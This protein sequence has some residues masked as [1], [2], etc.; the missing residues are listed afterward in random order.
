MNR[1]A[2]ELQLEGVLGHLRLS[3]ESLS[4]KE[5]LERGGDFDMLSTEQQH[6]YVAEQG[7]MDLLLQ[8]SSE[9]DYVV[10][11]PDTGHLYCIVGYDFR[12]H[13]FTTI[14]EANEFIAALPPQERD[15]RVFAIMKRNSGAF[16]SYSTVAHVCIE[17]ENTE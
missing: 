6:L 3:S 4:I 5:F 15:G 14:E 8:C 1:N 13:L 17:K 7:I 16:V 12:E 11:H 10:F 9:P 2:L